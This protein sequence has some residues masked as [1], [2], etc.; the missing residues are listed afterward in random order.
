MLKHVSTLCLVLAI[1]FSLALSPRLAGATQQR[2]TSHK[3]L[4][5]QV[6]VSAQLVP[7]LAIDSAGNPVYDL[8]QDELELTVNG[9]PARIIFFN[10]FRLDMTERG[11]GKVKG[12]VKGNVKG[13]AGALKAKAPERLHFIIIDTM[14]SNLN[15]MGISRVIAMRIIEKSTPGD[16]FVILES[17]QVTGIQHVAGPE[18]N[19]KKLASALKSIEKRFKRRNM[20][21]SFMRE[22]AASSRGSNAEYV[23]AAIF[24]IG[25]NR[26]AREREKYQNDI[27]R[28]AHSLKQLKYALKTT[29]LPKT[30]YLIS[31]GI[32]SNNLVENQVTYM[33]FLEEAARAINYGG[34]LFFLINPLRQKKA[35]RGSQLKFMADA[36]GGKFISGTGIKDVVTQVK[37][38][39]SAYYELAFNSETKAGQKNR[40]QLTCTRRGVK[41]TTIAHSEQG[42]PYKSM[43]ATEKKLFV[44]N[45]V[46]GGSWSRMVTPVKALKYKILDASPPGKSSG[47]VK[48][49]EIAMPPELVNRKLHLYHVAI[50]EATRKGGFKFTEKTAGVKERIKFEL[51]QGRKYYFV[52]ID[53][54]GGG[55]VFNRVM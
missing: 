23:A 36:A 33:R 22:L 35:G 32:R 7:I 47:T 42:R 27:S 25:S 24:G 15:T 26:G 11:Q 28:F 43:N 13:R 50:D 6:S 2:D 54:A 3:K 31:A 51:K 8:K 29:T 45:I 5:Y 34:S 4:E 37:K 55:C 52:Y 12:N 14:I 18:K 20:N 40:I 21:Q 30:V 44:L 38:S 1:S 16:A 17:N 48:E 53:P 9:K 41:L 49:I 39:T 19:K 46:S 10:G